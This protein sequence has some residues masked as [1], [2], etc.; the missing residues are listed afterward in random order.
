MR[1]GFAS[2]EGGNVYGA[3]ATDNRDF[4]E[5][6]F[7]H[8]DVYAARIPLPDSRASTARAERRD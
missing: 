2:D 8:A 4:E 7:Q 3:W 6:L 5:F 1:G